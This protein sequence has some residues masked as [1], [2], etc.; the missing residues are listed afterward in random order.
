MKG[1][2]EVRLQRWGQSGT[3]SWG[4]WER[5]SLKEEVREGRREGEQSCALCK[6]RHL[7]RDYADRGTRRA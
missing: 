7:R 6:R 1:R 3:Q 5:F 2:A 4:P